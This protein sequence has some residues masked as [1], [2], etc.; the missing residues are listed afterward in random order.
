MI[1]ERYEERNENKMEKKGYSKGRKA[2]GK[3]DDPKFV[4]QRPAN[5][6][7]RYKGELA[8]ENQIEQIKPGNYKDDRYK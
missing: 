3:R 4:Q 1:G 7:N 5:Y 2:E 6:P 8:P